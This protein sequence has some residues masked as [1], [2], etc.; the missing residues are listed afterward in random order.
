MTVRIL[1][2]CFVAA[3]LAAG[4]ETRVSPF[5]ACILGGVETLRQDESRV[6]LDCPVPPGVLLVGLP[7]RRVTVDE[8]IAAGLSRRLA[9]TLLASG[10]TFDRWCEAKEFEQP[11]LL[12]EGRN[13]D[14]PVSKSECGS[15]DVQIQRVLQTRSARVRVRLVRSPDGRAILDAFEPE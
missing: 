1:L 14:V 9:E 4:C 10:S 6:E 5:E 12:P 7:G 2:W 11:P 13:I 15:T 8:G 3:G